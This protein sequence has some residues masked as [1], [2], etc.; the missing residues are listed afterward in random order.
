MKHN[1]FVYLDVPFFLEHSLKVIPP[2]DRY[3]KTALAHATTE[4]EFLRREGLIKM[5]SVAGSAPVKEVVL[6]LSDL[7]E[8]GQDFIL[9]GATRNW[10]GACDRKSS[11][12]LKKGASEEARLAVYSDSKGLVSRL[13]RFRKQRQSQAH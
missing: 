7:T 6:R 13:E 4:I 5:D 9:S 1:D 10:L 2:T 12:L 8:E 3:A 11:D